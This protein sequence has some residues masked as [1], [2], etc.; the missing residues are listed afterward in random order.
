MY[1]NYYYYA[2]QG[3]WLIIDISC[4]ISYQKNPLQNLRTYHSIIP[5]DNLVTA[6]HNL[7][8]LIPPQIHSI[9]YADNSVV[10]FLCHH[11]TTVVKKDV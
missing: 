11:H 6:E 10:S 2:L 9:A 3:M 7:Q 1:N 8:H 5:L 4:S